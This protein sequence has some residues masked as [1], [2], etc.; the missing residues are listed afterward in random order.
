[1][2]IVF[3]LDGVILPDERGRGGVDAYYRREPFPM[4][5]KYLQQLKAEGHYIIIHTARGMKTN[6]GN[7]NAVRA[8]HERRLKDWLARYKIPHDELHFGKPYA[9]VYIDDKALNFQGTKEREAWDAL[10]KTLHAAQ[11]LKDVE[12]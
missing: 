12:P 1:M 7:I 6:A 11:K 3:D 8:L 4:A 2:R 5:V 9:D 10:V